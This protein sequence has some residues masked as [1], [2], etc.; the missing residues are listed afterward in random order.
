[1]RKG[2]SKNKGEKM[3]QKIDI[4]NILI[5]IIYLVLSL[6]MYSKWG[7]LMTL[8]FIFIALVFIVTSFFNK[9]PKQEGS[10]FI[11]FCYL[12]VMFSMI[13]PFIASIYRKDITVAIFVF[14]MAIIFFILYLRGI[15][16]IRRLK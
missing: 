12:L 7:L 6:I 10:K 3:K 14:L 5:G 15:K 1:M 11:I 2:C 16:S 8:F 13:F 4:Y 9:N